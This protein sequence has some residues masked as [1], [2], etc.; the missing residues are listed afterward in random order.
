MFNQAGRVS[1]VTSNTFPL[2]V[3]VDPP[4]LWPPLLHIFPSVFLSKQP[5]AVVRKAP[6]SHA[7]IAKAQVVY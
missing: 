3:S 2:N 6:V 7:P 4:V 1:L 5:T